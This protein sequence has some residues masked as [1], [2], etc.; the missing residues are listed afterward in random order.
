MIHVLEPAI[1]SGIALGAS[2]TFSPG[3]GNLLIM[4]SALKSSFQRAWVFSLGLLTADLTFII[5]FSLL[6]SKSLNF[7][8]ES[9]V[10]KPRVVG[11]AT[12]IYLVL[13]GIALFSTQRKRTD[14]NSLK[15][16]S[17]TY[18]HGVGIGLINPYVPFFWITA[19]AVDPA[20]FPVFGAVA[21]VITALGDVFKITVSRQA[22]GSRL[23]GYARQY[24][25]ALWIGFCLF[26][27]LRGTLDLFK[28]GPL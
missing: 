8:Q 5:A 26:Q 7:L 12:V 25:H 14:L 1:L 20:S 28:A 27:A 13:A 22:G 2:L 3:P 4:H 10:W 21:L 6:A 11:L 23:G 18:F 16:E 15:S 9:V 19:M 24:G 17:L